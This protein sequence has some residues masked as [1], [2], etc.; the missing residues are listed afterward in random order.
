VPQPLFLPV[1]QNPLA[2]YLLARFP[3]RV[4]RVLGLCEEQA[5]LLTFAFHLAILSPRGP[6]C[7]SRAEAGALELG[8]VGREQYRRVLW[9]ARNP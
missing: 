8:T 3:R 5:P 1:E 6:R 2:A 9:S 4:F 7:S